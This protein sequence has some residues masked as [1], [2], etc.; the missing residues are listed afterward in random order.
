MK[1]TVAEK[2]HSILP[3]TTFTFPIQTFPIWIFCVFSFPK[4]LLREGDTRGDGS[5]RS[6][7]KILST[8]MGWRYIALERCW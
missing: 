3:I 6:V 4:L 1:R 2:G 5:E 7:T 8:V